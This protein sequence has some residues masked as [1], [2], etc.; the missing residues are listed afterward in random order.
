MINYGQVKSSIRPQ[1][2]EITSE[3]VFIA[4]NITSYEE[5]VDEHTIN[6]YIYNYV[7]YDKDEYIAKNSQ[8]IAALQEELIATK[9]LLG[10]E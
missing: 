8:D 10:V 5:T 6:G 9:I 7:S 3:K 2:I 4:S 1:E